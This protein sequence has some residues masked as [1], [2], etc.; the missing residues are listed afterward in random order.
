MLHK[1]NWLGS[2]RRGFPYQ[3][4]NAEGGQNVPIVGDDGMF[5]IRE[6]ILGTDLLDSSVAITKRVNLGHSRGEECS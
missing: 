3:A 1:H 4:W 2:C 6:T 5:L